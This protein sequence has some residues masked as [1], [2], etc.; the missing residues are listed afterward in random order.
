M[1][2]KSI[3]I[4]N[5]RSIKDLEIKM[6]NVYDGGNCTI[7]VGKNEAGKSNILKAIAAVF[8]N[9][10]IKAGDRRK[11]IANEVID[12]NDYF[13]RAVIAMDDEDI[14]AVVELFK[15]QY[16][17]SEFLLFKN[18]ET[19]RDFVNYYCRE[20]LLR[21]KISENAKSEFSLLSKENTFL[22]DENVFLNGN[23]ITNIQQGVKLTHENLYKILSELVKKYYDGN[24]YICHY[25]KYDTRYLLPNRVDINQFKEDPTICEPL[26]NLFLLC[27]R[28]DIKSEFEN[29]LKEDGD[30][31]NLL[32][33]I[34]NGA[35]EEFRK[36]WPDFQNT[37]IVLQPYGNAE[38]LI[39]IVDNAF[40]TCDDRSDGFKHFISI[41]LMLST[42]NRAKALGE[43]DII[44]ID[45]PDQSLYP[46][47]ARF[48]RDELL[49]ISENSIVLY[50]THSQYMIDSECIE[51]HKV[52][53]K[54]NDVTKFAKED[55]KA[56][57]YDDQ[58]LR[59][60]IGTS[61]FEPLKGENIIFEGWLDK[62]L[63]KK[64]SNFDKKLKKFYSDIGITHLDGIKHVETLVKI[65]DLA[66]KK[67]IVV[68]D[69]DKVSQE[70]GEEFIKNN[71]EYKDCWL[72]YGDVC[73]GIT[74]MEDFFKKEYLERK[75]KEYQSD[76][77]YDENKNAIQ[78]I[79]NISDGDRERKQE[80]KNLL[81]QDFEKDD[82]KQEYHAFVENL[83]K[84]IDAL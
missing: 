34:S 68:A 65:M 6:D 16:Q 76:F 72:A 70:R 44:V 75:L 53:V 29:A 73:N 50:A 28:K 15:T 52:V 31:S 1:K 71:P 40:Y 45:E 37:K 62:T 81:V 48:L 3:K 21:C 58:L 77:S 83:K 4:K 78:N 51:R 18:G 19:L 39:K 41:L 30:Y 33:Q 47:S 27:N 49:K 13:V 25:W 23:L 36:I 60:A 20:I 80:I 22:V 57:Y 42:K 9:Y 64:F 12:E 8:N 66:R 17:G 2:L 43:K 84:R 79:E 55:K 56:E 26:K 63:F 5:F 32:S 74:T 82:I 59:N 46:S 24:Q 38:F 7:F 69:S 54:E 35:T 11:R 67:F 10:D 14:D 61:I